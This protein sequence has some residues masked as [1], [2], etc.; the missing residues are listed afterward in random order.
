MGPVEVVTWP[1][2]PD[3][4]TLSIISQWEWKQPG[5]A[6]VKPPTLLGDSTSFS[7]S[8][9]APQFPHLWANELNLGLRRLGICTVSSSK[10]LV[11]PI[12][13]HLRKYSSCSISPGKFS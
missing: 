13:A 10:A 7:V 2:C 11:P 1:C 6:G 9:S 5:G 8:S 3:L 12:V 4:G